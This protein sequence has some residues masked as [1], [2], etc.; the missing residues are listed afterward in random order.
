VIRYTTDGTTPTTSSPQYSGPISV[1]V[2][3]SVS[4]NVGTATYT[5][6]A[7]TPTF[8]PPAGTYSSSQSVT[9]SDASPGVTI[10]FTTDGSTPTT[11]STVY[12][13]P[14]TVSQT[15]T[16]QAIAAQTGWT[17]S[18]VGSAAYTITASAP[19]TPTFSPGAGTY[20]TPQSVTISDTTTGALIYYTTDGTTPT[21]S[22]PQYSA[23]ISVAVTTTIKAIAVTNS[24]KSTVASAKYTLQAAAPTF[25]L[26]AGTYTGPQSLTISDASPGVTIYYTTNGTTPTTSSTVYTG[27]ITVSQTETVKAIAAEAGWTSS[28]VAN[29]HYK[30]R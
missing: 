26:P 16:V 20:N 7:A 19:A 3:N 10:Y 5:L 13:G 28:S 29:A 8:N 11:S 24:V 12:S 6:Q 1:A 21:T 23:P 18:S 2:S 25:N 4:S 22:S 30:I 15:E 17:N 9:I 14:I 27:P